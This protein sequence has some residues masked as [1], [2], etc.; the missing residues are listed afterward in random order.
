MLSVAQAAQAAIEAETNE[1]TYIPPDLIKHTPGF[2][3]A[4][5]HFDS[6]T[7]TPTILGSHGV[8]SLTD[9]GVGLTTI[10]FDTS[11][12]AADV[13][14]AVGTHDAHSRGSGPCKFAAYATG[15]I[16]VQTVQEEPADTGAFV[17]AVDINAVIFGD[18]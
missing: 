10:N 17:D 13:Q 8:S 16:Q 15:S 7:G 12:S 6:N 3:K 18:F 1:S 11:M 2:A 14:C 9:N 4:W 5:V